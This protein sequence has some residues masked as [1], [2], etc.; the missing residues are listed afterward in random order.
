VPPI[1]LT[2]IRVILLDIEGTT[3]PLDFVHRTLFGYARANLRPFL[4][5]NLSKPEVH[6]YVANL[7]VQHAT[8]DKEKRMPPPWPT[9]SQESEI[10]SAVEYGLWLMDR[11]SKAGALK[12]LQG[13]MW[14]QGYRAGELKGQV[15]ADVPGALDR[16]CRKAK[17]V[18]IYSSGS[19][20]AQQL[21]FSTT[22]FGDLTRYISAFFDTRVG[23]KTS[24]ES[25]RQIASRKGH[26]EDEILFLSDSLA[27]LDAARSA[28]L[29]TALV[30][31][32]AGHGSRQ[33]GHS[34]I[35]SFDELD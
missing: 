8:D 9:G 23:A 2:H 27:E 6:R 13:L 17:D 1:D 5:A 18:S 25:Y 21:L 29:R 34:I 22:A 32:A 12:A 4:E 14:Q 7:K 24:G 20:L 30:A 10:T 33:E 19:E 16:W 11:D 26:R 31:R 15:Y 28:T 35:S 3:T